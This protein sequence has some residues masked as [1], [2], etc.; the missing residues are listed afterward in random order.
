[1]R[2]SVCSEDDPEKAAFSK[3]VVLP[4]HIVYSIS[5]AFLHFFLVF[6]EGEN[7]V[8]DTRLVCHKNSTSS[9]G[10]R[11]W[12]CSLCKPNFRQAGLGSRPSVWPAV[13]SGVCHRFKW[14]SSVPGGSSAPETG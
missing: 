6:T 10:H 9:S 4:T 7:I 5:K 12:F 14:A 13:L 8:L 11:V 3:C 2:M 1:M